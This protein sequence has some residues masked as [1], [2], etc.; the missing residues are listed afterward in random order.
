MDLTEQNVN[1]LKKTIKR[2]IGKYFRVKPLNIK[3]VLRRLNN[4]SDLI[5]LIV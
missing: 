4:T 2:L 1:P 5:F 3:N